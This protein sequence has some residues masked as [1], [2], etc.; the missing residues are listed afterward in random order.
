MSNV[1]L[2]ALLALLVLSVATLPPP[3][4][5]SHNVDDPVPVTSFAVVASDLG[6][7][8]GLVHH[9]GDRVLTLT[10]AGELWSLNATF[11]ERVGTVPLDVGN[12]LDPTGLDRDASGALF[13]DGWKGA[14]RFA[15]GAAAPV[16]PYRDGLFGP[17]GRLYFIEPEPR[18]DSHVQVLLAVDGLRRVERVMDVPWA[19]DAAFAP[20]GALFLLE[21]SSGQVARADLTTRT[22]ARLGAVGGGLDDVA[23]DSLGR[24]YVAHGHAQTVERFDFSTGEHVLLGK[25]ISGAAPRLAFA[26]T[27]LWATT[28]PEGWSPAPHPNVVGYFET[29]IEGFPGFHP[30]FDLAPLPNLVLANVEERILDESGEVR[31]IAFTVTNDGGSW[32]GAGW[33]AFAHRATYHSPSFGTCVRHSTTIEGCNERGIG[34]VAYGAQLAPGESVE[35]VIPWDTRDD[36]VLGAQ[37][38]TVEVNRAWQ[39]FESTHDDNVASFRTYVKVDTP[40]GGL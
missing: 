18:G 35:L 26:G 7:P 24:L 39:P 19:F 21:W 34:G 2:R 27:K 32:M 15:D 29:G 16:V 20:D 33:G 11:R 12:D 13:V 14:H 31:E 1:P 38:V 3:T 22:W 37:H 6:A 17:D 30:A 36:H 40:V 28:G 9:E 23:V 25:G 10:E 4:G 5:A 8:R